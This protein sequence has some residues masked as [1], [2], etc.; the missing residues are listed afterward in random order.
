MPRKYVSSAGNFCSVCVE[1]TFTSR[2]RALTPM[3][4]GT[5]VH[6][7]GCNVRDQDKSWASHVCWTSYQ[8]KLNAWVNRKE[9]CMLSAVSIKLSEPTN[10][11]TDTLFYIVSPNQKG[12]TMS[13]RDSGIP[14]YTIG[15][16][17]SASL[18]K[19]A[20]SRTP[21][22]F[23]PRV[24]RKKRIHVKIHRSHLFQGFRNF[25]ERNLS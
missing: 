23:L 4:K 17:S 24:M 21:R 10:H 8:S 14:K 7:F 18:Q 9:C 22:Q 16:S 13:K 2:K 12:I 6:Y 20:Y 25:P 19:S 3:I 15:Y 5:E 11:L 1:T